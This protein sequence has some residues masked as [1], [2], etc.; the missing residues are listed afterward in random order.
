[1]KVGS[2]TAAILNAKITNYWIPRCSLSHWLHHILKSLFIKRLDSSSNFFTKAGSICNPCILFLCKIQKMPDHNYPDWLNSPY[3]VA[4]CTERI[5]PVVLS[6]A[7]I[8]QEVYNFMSYVTELFPK[9][10]KLLLHENSFPDICSACIQVWSEHSYSIS[11][12]FF[13]RYIEFSY[14]I[15]HP[16]GYNQ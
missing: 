8:F 2:N 3:L 16:H 11:P 13:E 14:G 7:S 1:M 4:S 6:L 5:W 15:L 10:G 9:G 12:W